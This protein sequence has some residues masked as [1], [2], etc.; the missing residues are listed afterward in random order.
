VS[1]R[2]RAAVPGIL[3]LLALGIV[4]AIVGLVPWLE[5]GLRL[6]LQNLWATSTQPDAM[7]LVL[8][9][10]SQYSITLIVAVIVVG[11][12]LAGGIARLLR[13]SRPRFGLLAV[14]AGVLLVQLVALVQTATVVSAGLRESTESTVYLAALVT[15]SLGS[16][17]VGMLVLSLI[18]RAPAAGATVAVAVA[19]VAAGSWLAGVLAPFGASYELLGATRWVPAII[20]GVALAR[21]GV[22]SVGRVIAVIASLGILWV[23]PAAVTAVSNA[24]GMRVYAAYPAE[25]TGYAAQ[26]FVAALDQQGAPLVLAVVLMVAGLGAAWLLRR[27]VAA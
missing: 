13:A 14:V 9:P 17:L 5:T 11:S 6:P 25:M 19:A 16:T 27:R 12:A 23:A 26:V 10:F 22:A 8:L 15:G 3:L 20:V 4:S 1:T 18:A 21:C 2:P 7:P 24:A